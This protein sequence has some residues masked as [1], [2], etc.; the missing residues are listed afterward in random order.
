MKLQRI[1]KRINSVDVVSFDIFDTL[2]ERRVDRPIDI[3]SIVGNRVLGSKYEKIFQQERIEA[4]R[5]ARDKSNNREVTLDE[6]YQELTKYDLS[7]QNALKQEEVKQELVGCYFKQEMKPVY[8]EVLKLE[9][10][11]FFISDMYLPK[12]VIEQMLH[13]CGIN[14]Y[15]KLYVSNEYGKNKLSGELFK[16][17]LQENNIG[18]NNMIHLGDSIKADWLGAYRAG[19]RSI[20]ISRKN[21]FERLVHK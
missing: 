3:F 17:V 19:V 11:V 8:N 9:K 13:K 2:I 16:I 4:E 12:D 7:V 5:L 6:I 1:R 18:P 14:G 15:E 20:L 10:R 21:R